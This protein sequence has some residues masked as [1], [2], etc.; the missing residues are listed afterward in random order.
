MLTFLWGSLSVPR[1][2]KSFWVTCI[3]YIE[4]V[5]V[6]KYVFQ[7]HFWP[8]I[9]LIKPSPFWWPRLLGIEKKDNYA[10]YDLILLLVLFFHRFMLKSLGL[11]DLSET[12]IKAYMTN[13]EL[14]QTRIEDN[15]E[16]QLSEQNPVNNNGKKS[17]HSK[18][19]SGSSGKKN[20]KNNQEKQSEQPQQQ[21]QQQEIS[22]DVQII[23]DP[24]PS[25]MMIVTEPIPPELSEQHL[26]ENELMI[27]QQE[28][29]EEPEG[30]EINFIYF[31]MEIP[32][33]TR[34][35]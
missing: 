16:Q 34:K 2:S 18:K 7:F 4:I 6:L 23:N 28:D 8:W 20:K 22:N 26:Y 5:V 14:F 25:S 9:E 29:D 13:A 10:N 12:E 3:T 24:L 15:N 31:L 27:Q 21:Q 11:W 30:D 19:K 17:K 33:R 35:R 32:I 1:P